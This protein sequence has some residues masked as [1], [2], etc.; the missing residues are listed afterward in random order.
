[1][2]LACL[3]ACGG[4]GGSAGS[5]AGP[6]RIELDGSVL[7][8]PGLQQPALPGPLRAA[9]DELVASG[10]WSWTSP[11]A[12]PLRLVDGP[13]DLGRELVE[14]GL[15][16]AHVEQLRFNGVSNGSLEALDTDWAAAATRA[17]SSGRG[18][19][20][21]AH[22]PGPRPLDLPLAGVCLPMHHKDFSV[23]YAW[24]LAEVAELGA[25][26]VNLIVVTQQQRNDSSEVPL[27]TLRTPPDERIRATIRA[28]RALGLRVQLM[29]VVLIAEPGPKDWRGTLAPTDRTAWWRSY[30]AFVCHMADL[31]REGGADVL[32][33]G[34][35]LASMEADEARWRQLA[36]NVRM[37]YAGS[38]TYSANWDH[39]A[40]LPFWDALDLAS[41]T[42]YFEVCQ[43]TT[44]GGARDRFPDLDACLRAGWRAGLSELRHLAA[45]SGLPTVYS[46][47]GIPSVEGALAK[48]WD[49]TLDGRAD[50]DGQR[51]AFEAFADVFL[52]GGR[53]TAGFGGAFLYDFWGEG[54]LADKTYT[55]RGKPAA[56][57]WR[58]ILGELDAAR[59]QPGGR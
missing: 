30:D 28:A 11:G 17:Q 22:A 41:M 8:L 38:L 6:V 55:P 15:A 23:D 57:V 20:A 25:R 16:L 59:Q 39:F 13:R 32:C 18:L 24:E 40:E 10:D 51:R 4:R 27:R 36:Q 21:P 5:P 49:Y 56:E 9:A 34:S 43:E 54:G 14:A 12:G 1:M 2:A 7:D 46:E 53:P 35:E 42:G 48:P 58:R 47:V 52:P 31:A 45:V 26:W 50:P 29:P 33:L 19:F 37:R 44:F 3:G